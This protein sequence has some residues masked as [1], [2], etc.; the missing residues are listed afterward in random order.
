MTT[1]R[2]EDEF[3]QVVDRVNVK[4]VLGQVFSIRVSCWLFLVFLRH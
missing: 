2:A 1:F 3:D 4:M